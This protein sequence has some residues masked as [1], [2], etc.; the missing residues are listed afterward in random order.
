MDDERVDRLL[1]ALPREMASP[2]FTA[3]V[4]A[5][6]DE[7]V[8][9]GA[10]TNARIFGLPRL[11]L[12]AAVLAATLAVAASLY[13]QG[14]GIPPAAR[15]PLAPTLA[16]SLAQLQPAAPAPL[17]ILPASTRATRSGG[18]SAQRAEAM[19]QQIRAQHLRLHD[20]VRRLREAQSSTVYLGGDEDMDLV[21][22]L[23]RVREQPERQLDP[24][25]YP[26][27]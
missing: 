15:Q 16:P 21:I 2:G 12:P 22:H 18:M 26:F 10:G 25:P 6:L 7:E 5:R 17:P 11:T 13:L 20:D 27:H 3:R 9:A 23:D 19:L 24:P 8:E 14:G 1:R 4:L